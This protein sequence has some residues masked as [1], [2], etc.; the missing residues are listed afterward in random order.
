MQTLNLC[1]ECLDRPGL[2][3][4]IAQTIASY[5]HNIKVCLLSSF[6]PYQLY[7]EHACESLPFSHSWQALGSL[8]PLQCVS[9]DL[10]GCCSRKENCSSVLLTCA[11]NHRGC[12]SRVSIPNWMGRGWLLS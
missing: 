7:R 6:L 4:E 11:R 5:G 10:I 1:I 3:A 8:P 2:L 12:M 9:M